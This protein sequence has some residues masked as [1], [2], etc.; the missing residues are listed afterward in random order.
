[1]KKKLLLSIILAVFGTNFIFSQNTAIPACSFNSATDVANWS[2]WPTN[3]SKQWFNGGCVAMFVD[4]LQNNQPVYITSPIF[5]IP[6]SGNYEL[7]L[8]YGL[9][10]SASPV[11]FELITSPAGTTVTM[12]SNSTIAGTCTSWPNP[13]I[14]KLNYTGLPAGNYRLRATL[15]NNSQFFIEGLK[16]NV[17]YSTMG[18]DNDLTNFTFKTYPNP[19]NG[20][21]F[22]QLNNNFS[23]INFLKIFSLQG[24]L[25]YEQKITSPNQEIKTTKFAPGVYLLKIASENGAT[26]H[27]KIIIL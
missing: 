10:Y 7:E 2:I 13:K 15:P 18:L 20:S 22:V 9:V 14:S 8:R 6:N 11:L 27:Q 23:E 12:S 4:N 16:S 17:N 1:M 25:L 26:S 21:F 5:N 3:V 24:K 19:N